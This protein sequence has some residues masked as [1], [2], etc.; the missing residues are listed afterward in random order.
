MVVASVGSGGC[1]LIEPLQTPSAHILPLWFLW[2]VTFFLHLRHWLPLPFP[3][4]FFPSVG[5]PRRV[6]RDPALTWPVGLSFF[7]L[8]LQ[9]VGTGLWLFVFHLSLHSVSLWI[10]AIWL[11]RL[12]LPTLESPDTMSLPL[13]DK[14][15]L[16]LS[17][18]LLWKL[19][20]LT[21][22]SPLSLVSGSRKSKGLSPFVE[23]QVLRLCH[24]SIEH[25]IPHV[26]NWHFSHSFCLNFLN[27]Y[28]HYLSGLI[29]STS[30]HLFKPF[31]LLILFTDKQKTR[32]LSPIK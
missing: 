12:S 26:T 14:V 18:I 17:F 4:Y 16:I 29:L 9:G 2:F 7:F 22:L 20:W 1:Y 28:D 30:P 23:P 19:T 32:V 15:K 6:H 5:A 3:F 21:P 10:H 8:K 31:R 27:T 11:H 25:S 24:P 13:F